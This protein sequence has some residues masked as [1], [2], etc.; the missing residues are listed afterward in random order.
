MVQINPAI[1]DWFKKRGISESNVRAM[2]IYSGQ[3][4]QDG[5]GGF[6][7]DPDPQ[8]NIIVFPYARGGAVLNEKYRA[9]GKKFFQ[10]PGGLSIF[11]NV[12]VLRETAVTDG[13]AALVITEGEIDVLSVRE[14]GYPYV[15]SVPDGAPPTKVEETEDD[16]PALSLTDKYGYILRDWD[17]L[18]KAKRVV[19]ATDSDAPGRGLAEAL[20]RR[21]GRARCS[22]VSYPEDCK[23][24]NEVLLR[25]GPAKVASMIAEAKPY[26]VSGV[27]TYSDLPPEPEFA[28][29]STGF[30]R[31]DDYLRL[32][33]PALMVVTGFAGSGKSSLV[34]QIVAQL[35]IL[36]GWKAALASFEMRVKPYVTD[37]LQNTF[38]EKNPNADEAACLGW[39]RENFVFIAPEP[40]KED[41]SF[42][43][44]WIVDKAIT[45]VVRHDVRVLV[46]D[47]WNEIEHALGKRESLTDYTGRAIRALKRFG[48]EFECLV[49]VVAHPTKSAANKQPQDVSLYDVSDSAHFANKADFGLVVARLGGDQDT[50]SELHVRKVRY[51]PMSGK[52]GSISVTYDLQKRIFSQ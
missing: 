43:I 20:V 49:I 35:S 16:D 37:V 23:D 29:V 52:R 32:F 34:N 30:G 11:W 44:D 1:L 6:A 22:F 28:P 24:F 38:Y 2:G 13:R 40:S 51:Q 48:R 14:A 33:Y 9:S 19:I 7:I 12:D 27:Y 46:I 31:L 26:P 10:K 36:H 39:L 5:D 15:V 4:R 41:T 17:A 45:A 18:Q 50:V 47:P 25:H 3:Q 42:D 21:L 8:G